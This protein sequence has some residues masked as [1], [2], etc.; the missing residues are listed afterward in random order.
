MSSQ[1]LNATTAPQHGFIEK[2]RSA[3]AWVFIPSLLLIFFSLYLLASL[4]AAWKFLGEHY[5]QTYYAVKAITAVACFIY[6]IVILVLN[7]NA[8]SS[9]EE[10]LSYIGSAFVMLFAMYMLSFSLEALVFEGY[11]PWPAWIR[12][13]VFSGLS[14]GNNLLFLAAAFKLVDRPPFPKWSFYVQAGSWL[15]GMWLYS[16]DI[17]CH[18]FPGVLASAFCIGW[19]GYALYVNIYRP[20]FANRP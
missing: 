13:L 15:I 19:L 9:P 1:I 20:D 6:G 16:A 12:Q 17:F 7:R 8:L 14:A 2:I 11:A 10:W 4:P 3:Y 18:R 5:S